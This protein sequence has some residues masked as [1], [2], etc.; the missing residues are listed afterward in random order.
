[1]FNI[2]T[3]HI[4]WCVVNFEVINLWVF[5]LHADGNMSDDDR[6]SDED[7]PMNGASHADR[8]RTM[9]NSKDNAID[10]TDN[11]TTFLPLVGQPQTMT[12]GVANAP[13]IR[14]VHGSRER[15]N[16]INQQNIEP[17]PSDEKLMDM[18]E[19]EAK[20]G[21]SPK[22]APMPFRSGFAPASPGFG[23]SAS[24]KD[25][26]SDQWAGSFGEFEQHTR[27]IGIKLLTRMGFRGRLGKHG[28]GQI[29]PVAITLGTRRNVRNPG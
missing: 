22:N 6:H 14:F 10:F 26:S 3:L 13:L 7:T 28:Q 17:E 5:L 20:D 18:Y 11:E 27:G 1:M 21:S 8:M 2:F 15:F 12:T 25:V 16:F 19:D 4:R 23:A 24:A 9:G 29:T